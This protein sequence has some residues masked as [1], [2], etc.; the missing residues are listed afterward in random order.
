MYDNMLYFNYH[1]KW[2]LIKYLLYTYNHVHYDRGFLLVEMLWLVTEFPNSII[3][4]AFKY[5]FATLY[6]E[7]GFLYWIRIVMIES[8]E[9]K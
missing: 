9:F 1:M 3:A 2:A 4:Y 8:T 6:I 7:C 5:L